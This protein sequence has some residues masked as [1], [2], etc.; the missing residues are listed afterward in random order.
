MLSDHKRTDDW[1][2]GIKPTVY[3]S[4]ATALTNVLLSFALAEGVV[5][6]FWRR[7]KNRS[8]LRDLH[9][10]WLSGNSFLGALQGTLRRTALVVGFA[11]IMTTVSIARGPLL[12]QA[13][14]VGNVLFSTEDTMEVHVAQ[15][16]PQQYT[17][18]P[19]LTRVTAAETLTYL[20][21][22]FTR[23]LQS[24]QNHE[25]MVILN[26]NCGDSCSTSVKAFGFG[27]TCTNTTVDYDFS[28]NCTAGGACSVGTIVNVF[29]TNASM[30]SI[31]T[32]KENSGFQ[33]FSALQLLS[34]FIAVPSGSDKGTLQQQSCTLRSGIVEYPILITNG[35]VSFLSRDW[36]NDTFVE[37]LLLDPLPSFGQGGYIVAGFAEAASDLFSSTAS[38]YDDGVLGIV[39]QFSGLMANQYLKA[40]SGGAYPA[41][42]DMSWNDPM[43]DMINIM[44]QIAFRTALHAAADNPLLAN[45]TQTTRYTGAKKQTIYVTDYRFLVFG[46]IVSLLGIFAVMPTLWGWWEDGREVS[47][48]P[49]E[50][51][52]AFDAPLLASADCNATSAQ[53]LRQVGGKGVRYGAV[54][55]AA[56]ETGLTDMASHL[57]WRK[58]VICEASLASK[59]G[60]GTTFY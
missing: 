30:I 23:V 1:G 55:R 45:A 27:V 13:T 59:P 21:S 28:L 4:M 39:V 26:S 54:D 8:T 3:L 5:I 6:S 7:A 24:Y 50:V 49:L 47:L 31:D 17:S 44:R 10:Y 37:E 33:S 18:V 20:T 25:D 38:M 22:N 35:T 2:Y 60:V 53:L 58:L 34:S 46:A 14:S 42:L 29:S 11:C 41:A 51:A 36:R 16:L 48:S 43:D 56:L 40:G 12:Q 9:Q 19:Q 52:K 57:R 15:Q 32:N